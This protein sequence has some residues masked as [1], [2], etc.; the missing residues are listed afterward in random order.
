MPSWCGGKK[1]TYIWS[2]W[3]IFPIWRNTCQIIL[4]SL[5][6]GGN[7]GRRAEYIL[8]WQLG[9]CNW[10]WSSIN[11]PNWVIFWHCF[12]LFISFRYLS[13][14]LLLHFYPD[15]I[16]IACN[17]N[18]WMGP[19]ECNKHFVILLCNVDFHGVLLNV[20][21]IWLGLG[22]IP[23]D[24]LIEQLVGSAY[25]LQSIRCFLKQCFMYRAKPALYWQVPVQVHSLAG[26]ICISV[27]SN[28]ILV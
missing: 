20:D 21:S 28:L 17:Q 10:Y 18:I 1:S 26:A 9:S 3:C 24:Q 13:C 4:H 8:W 7:C 6:L 14:L 2:E 11:I 15:R 5:L 12:L 22:C 19:R 16:T 25:W 27:E 23:V